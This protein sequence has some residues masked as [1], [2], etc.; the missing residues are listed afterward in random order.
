MNLK[1]TSDRNGGW[2]LWVTPTGESDASPIYAAWG[3]THVQIEALLHGILAEG[4]CPAAPAPAEP[5]QVEPGAFGER[6][7]ALAA[8]LDA[9]NGWIEGVQENHDSMPHRGENTGEECWRQF[10]PADIRAM[11]NDAARQLGVAEFAA[12]KRPQED[13]KHGTAQRPSR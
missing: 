13:A 1:I 9:L 2:N 6:R 8:V 4:P 5:G 11:V 10:A 3:R 7:A 12:P